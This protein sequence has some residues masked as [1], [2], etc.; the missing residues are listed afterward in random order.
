M[1]RDRIKSY[2]RGNTGKIIG[3][4]IGL[5]FGILVLAL[6]LWRS[7]LLTAFI[8]AGFWLGSRVDSG[9]GLNSIFDKFNR[10]YRNH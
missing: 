8:G 10:D 4:G 6:G 3:M 5:V 7:I 1:D 9:A 2:I